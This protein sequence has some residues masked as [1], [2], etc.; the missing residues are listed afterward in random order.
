MFN[1]PQL[2]QVL[3][4]GWL[5]FSLVLSTAYRSSL[6]AHLSVLTKLP[7]IDSFEDLLMQ[8]DWTWGI[9]PST[10]SIHLYFTFASDP[11][12]MEVNRKMQEIEVYVR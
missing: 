5:V 1:E 6:I 11:V 4:G 8:Q 3:L 10:G 2:P 9:K 12:R 7:P